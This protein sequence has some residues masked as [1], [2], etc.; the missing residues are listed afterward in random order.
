MIDHE[1]QA[2]GHWFTKETDAGIVCEQCKKLMP[3]RIVAKG[4]G[5]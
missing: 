3:W 2:C 4:D 1:K 5:K